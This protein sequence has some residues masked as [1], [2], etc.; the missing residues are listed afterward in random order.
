MPKVSKEALELLR[1]LARGDGGRRTGELLRA[2]YLTWQVTDKGM[3][4]LRGIANNGES[5]KGVL[6]G[7]FEN[8]SVNLWA[9]HVWHAIYEEE[10]GMTRS[11]CGWTFNFRKNTLTEKDYSNIEDITEDDICPRCKNEFSNKYE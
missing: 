7:R 11:L 10:Y 1:K 5:D 4:A 2:G 9:D 8:S 3:E 6:W